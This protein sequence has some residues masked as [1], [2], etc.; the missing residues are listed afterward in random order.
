MAT[1]DPSTIKITLLSGMKC[2]DPYVPDPKDPSSCTV[3]KYKK[4]S[5]GP[6]INGYN[7]DTNDKSGMYCNLNIPDNTSQTS[8]TSQPSQPS[9]FGSITNS[10]IDMICPIGY[11]KYSDPSYSNTI[12]VGPANVT[13]TDTNNK[14]N[15]KGDIICEWGHPVKN[16]NGE[17]FCVYE[18]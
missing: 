2:S 18:Y 12:C 10:T 11:Y 13:Y 16:N 3:L 14:W 9:Q 1:T 6:C 5:N 8:H 15:I 17:L 7:K 4:L